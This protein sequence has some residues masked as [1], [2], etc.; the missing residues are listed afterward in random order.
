MTIHLTIAGIISHAG[1]P[2]GSQQHRRPNGCRG[3]SNEGSYPFMQGILFS[4]C[5]EYNEQAPLPYSTHFRK[6]LND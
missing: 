1:P 4:L 2:F 3:N 5:L 6:L